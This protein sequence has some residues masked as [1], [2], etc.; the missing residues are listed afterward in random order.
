MKLVSIFIHFD[1]YQGWFVQIIR[2][3]FLNGSNFRDCLNSKSPVHKL[4]DSDPLLVTYPTK[5][6]MT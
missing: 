5:P 6:R 4:G 3:R 2:S 1:Q